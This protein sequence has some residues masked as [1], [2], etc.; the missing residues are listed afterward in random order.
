M[1]E[2]I[3]F[4][5][6][7]REDQ[8]SLVAELAEVIWRE[9]YTPIIKKPQVDY[10]LEH[11]QSKKAISRQIADN[12][13]Y[14]LIMQGIT[15]VGYLAIQKKDQVLFLS[16]IYLLKEFRGMGMGKSAMEFIME[17]AGEFGCDRI[18]LTVNKNNDRSIMAYSKMGFQNKGAKVTDIGGGFSM[19][20]YLMVN[21]FKP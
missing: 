4:S 12:L 14:F 6:V 8:V 2:A 1:K 15:A 9:H 17:K 16:K 5:A 13:E 19:D 20:D 7:S 11:F 10:M 3:T 21:Y 18:A